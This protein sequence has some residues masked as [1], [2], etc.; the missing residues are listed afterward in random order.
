ME[1]V[2]SKNVHTG[3]QVSKSF[4][5]KNSFKQGYALSPLLFYFVLEFIIRKIQENKT[6]F[7]ELN[8]MLV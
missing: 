5:T 2:A 7:N 8:Q 6:D 3:G 1:Q 4:Q